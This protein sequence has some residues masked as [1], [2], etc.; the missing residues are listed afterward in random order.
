M[1]IVKQR[2]LE[3]DEHNIFGQDKHTIEFVE[4]FKF[5]LSLVTVYNNL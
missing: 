1:V 3:N 5:C 4:L 2:I